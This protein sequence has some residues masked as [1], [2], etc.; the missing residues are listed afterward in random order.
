MKKS[1]LALIF[2]LLSVQLFAQE[3]ETRSIYDFTS[4]S[5]SQSIR[6]ILK[7]GSQPEVVVSTTGELKDVITDVKGED[8]VIEM[9][10]NKSYRNIEVEVTV[11]YQELEELKASSSSRL[12]AEGLIK[13]NNIEIKGSSSARIDVEVDATN[14]EVSGSSSARIDVGVKSGN[15]EAKT[16]SSCRLTLS[17]YSDNFEAKVSS[18]GRIA[19]TN[20]TCDNADVSAS[21]SGRVEFNV[22]KELIAK[23]SSSGKIS[24]GGSPAIV[25]ADSSSGGKVSRM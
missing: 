23:A 14:V 12:S 10:S 22:E 15:V 20:F 2:V 3:T 16:S 6:V 4:V 19:A 21:S 17:G 1:L 11:Y 7:K 25:D 9:A 8:L 18:S 24:Y 13:A 5:S